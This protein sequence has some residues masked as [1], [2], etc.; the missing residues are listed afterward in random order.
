ML[1]AA[2][3]VCNCVYLKPSQTLYVTVHIRE[4]VLFFFIFYVPRR[5]WLKPFDLVLI[6][7]EGYSTSPQDERKTRFAKGWSCRPQ[8]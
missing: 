5:L 2:F 6:G 1:T 4:S 7:K 3:V 8:H